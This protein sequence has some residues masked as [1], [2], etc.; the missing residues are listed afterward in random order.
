MALDAVA[1]S[2]AAGLMG[3]FEPAS[4]FIQRWLPLFYIPSLVVL[5][6][7]VKDILAASGLKICFILVKIDHIGDGEG[8]VN[9]KQGIWVE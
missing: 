8:E 9:R 1:P 3:F 5:T 6:L 4:L 7:A 2:A